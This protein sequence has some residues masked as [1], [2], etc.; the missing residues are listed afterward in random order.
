MLDFT[1]CQEKPTYE[2]LAV[3]HR[4]TAVNIEVLF[5]VSKRALYLV[6]GVWHTLAVLP[7]EG[8]QV[9][10]IKVD[11][12]HCSTQPAV[13]VVRT[14]RSLRHAPSVDD[15]RVIRLPSL[16]L[17]YKCV[18]VR[19]GNSENDTSQFYC[20]LESR[21]LG[22]VSANDADHVE[23]AHLYR[24]SGELREQTLHPVYYDA[25]YAIPPGFY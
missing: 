18:L 12:V 6:V 15:I 8:E 11:A 10:Q 1:Q 23:V 2:P 13:R 24:V 5:E 3:F 21:L 9:W 19:C 25:F 22:E 20:R 7:L 16:V 14:A 4:Q 17:A